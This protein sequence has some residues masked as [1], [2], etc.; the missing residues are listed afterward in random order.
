MA[1]VA[2]N[3]GSRKRVIATPFRKPMIMLQ[4][5]ATATPS[6]GDTPNLM[7]PAARHADRVRL[8]ATDRSMP[9]H[10]IASV[11]PDA[12]RKSRLA[13]RRTLSRLAI[14]AKAP[15]LTARM[16]AIARMSTIL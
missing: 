14:D 9:P 12:R 13:W 11:S 10:R 6:H 7:A 8:A 3:G 15:V 5:N 1:Y 4:A 16:L 2:R